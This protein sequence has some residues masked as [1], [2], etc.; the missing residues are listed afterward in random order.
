MKVSLFGKINHNLRTN[1]NSDSYWREYVGRVPQ[2]A[3]VAGKTVADKN[4]YIGQGYVKNAGLIVGSIYPGVKEVHVPYDGD[5]KLD[6]YIKVS[7]EED[8]TQK[9]YLPVLDTVRSTRQFLLDVGK[10]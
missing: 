9:M 6:K 10:L 1:T 3:I 4:V 5:K 7:E 2:D 8:V